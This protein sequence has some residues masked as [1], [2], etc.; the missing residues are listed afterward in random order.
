M[1]FELC[2]V[3]FQ[4]C[5]GF[6]Q[7]WLYWQLP[8]SLLENTEIHIHQGRYTWTQDD[9]G[10]KVMMTS[11]ITC[12]N[13][14]YWT[15]L[16]NYCKPILW[17]FRESTTATV[18]A[19][20]NASTYLLVHERSKNKV[21]YFQCYSKENDI[22][23]SKVFSLVGTYLFI[24]VAGQ[25]LS[26]WSVWGEADWGGHRPVTG[27]SGLSLARLTLQT[28]VASR[29]RTEEVLMWPYIRFF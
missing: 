12:L 8:G 1:A 19:G 27:L 18:A 2:Y 20:I 5:L 21:L 17:V 14:L 9:K 10:Q 4:F 11:W 16:W 3:H 28:S 13:Q 24:W 22:I 6:C 26:Q 15:Y 23:C 25:R 7:L 29:R